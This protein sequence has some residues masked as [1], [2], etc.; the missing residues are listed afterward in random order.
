MEKL[1]MEAAIM[2]FEPSAVKPHDLIP[3]CFSILET[4][5]KKS[6]Q[7]KLDYEM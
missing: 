4:K 7:S 5:Q 3:D 6:E 2:A 1:W